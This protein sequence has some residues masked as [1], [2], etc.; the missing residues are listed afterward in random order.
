MFYVILWY[1]WC[2]WSIYNGEVYVCMSV[3][4]GRKSDQ[5]LFWTKIMLWG[6]KNIFVLKNLCWFFFNLLL[7]KLFWKKYLWFFLKNLVLKN[8]FEIFFVNFF[9]LFCENYFGMW[10]NYF[11]RW[12]NYFGRWENSREFLK[13][14]TWGVYSPN[15]LTIQL[16]HAGRR[17]AMA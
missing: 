9:L 10:E 2:W 4:L 14:R 11:G 6:V 15:N 1:W 16:G 13:Y 7:K 5:I 17:P 8:W 12:E 3:C